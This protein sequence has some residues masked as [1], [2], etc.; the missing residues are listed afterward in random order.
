MDLQTF[1]L[2]GDLITYN[3]ALSASAR[4]TAWEVAL[5][6]CA[7]LQRSRLQQD[8]VTESTLVSAV[9][10]A[11]DWESAL[12]LIRGS[13]SHDLVGYNNVLSSLRHW[14]RAAALLAD[15]RQCLRM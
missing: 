8:S 11:G 9:S 6:L 7:L 14:R 13:A 15:L 1:R 4:G 5:A 10:R 2:E 3:S 12:Q